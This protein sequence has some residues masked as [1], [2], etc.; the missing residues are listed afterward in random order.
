MKILVILQLQHRVV[1]KATFFI[2]ETRILVPAQARRISNCRSHT[3]IL[4]STDGDGDIFMAYP[5]SLFH[6]E[7]PCCIRQIFIGDFSMEQ[8]HW[9][10]LLIGLKNQFVEFLLTCVNLFALKISHKTKRL[11]SID[12]KAAVAQIPKPGCWFVV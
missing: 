4:I 10:K 9:S 1:R 12:R 3:N 11:R 8:T 2:T 7:R 6:F 5:A